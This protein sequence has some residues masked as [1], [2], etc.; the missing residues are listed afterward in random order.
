MTA[1]PRYAVISAHNRQ[2]LLTECIISLAPQCDRIIVIDNASDP[3]LEVERQLHRNLVLMVHDPGQPPNL[4]RLWN[5][6]LNIAHEAA[7][8][9]CNGETP[10]YDVAVFGDDVFVPGDWWDRVSS[11]MRETTAVMAATHSVAPIWQ[12]M[13]KTQPDS[14]IMNRAPG[15]AWMLRGEV[16]LRLDERFH[17]WFGDTDLDW[18]A[19]QAGGMIIAP[20]DIAVNREPNRFTNALPELGVRAGLDR[21]E[22]QDK[23]G[24]TPW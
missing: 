23:W 19:R 8:F 18:R 17:W 16:G 1:I 21:Y 2:K 22:F 3:P 12:A 7:C 24:W 10:V 5:R 6:G 9:M 4:S 14:D 11:V 13:L 15:W 20:G